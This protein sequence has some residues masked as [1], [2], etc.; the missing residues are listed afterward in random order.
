VILIL[1]ALWAFVNGAFPFLSF[2]HT[3]AAHHVEDRGR[4]L[5]AWLRVRASDTC[6]RFV[7]AEAMAPAVV[8]VTHC[9]VVIG[10]GCVGCCFTSVFI[11]A[12]CLLAT[13]FFVGSVEVCQ[14]VRPSLVGCGAISPFDEG[15][16]EDS[17]G[18]EVVNGSPDSCGF[19][20][21]VVWCSVCSALAD[22]VPQ[23]F[24]GLHGVPLA[25]HVPGV[26]LEIVHGDG[27]I[28]CIEVCK[29]LEDSDVGISKKIIF[30]DL[31]ERG[32]DSL[33]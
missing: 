9:V 7:W 10:R 2:D 25:M 18:F 33:D 28:S 17:T 16:R 21:R 4:F 6:V 31:Y 20:D 3:A 32:R 12:C 27:S 29:Y 13:A 14:E 8:E 19:G 11:V 26:C 22:L 5:V 30:E 1:L 23:I 24:N 15:V